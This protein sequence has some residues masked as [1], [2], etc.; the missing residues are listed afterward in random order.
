MI[1]PE[2]VRSIRQG[3]FYGVKSLVSVVLNEGLEVLGT[4]EQS[5][6]QLKFC[7]VFHESGL[8]RVRLPST[9]KVIR[10]EAFMGCKNLKSV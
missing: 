8:K 5:L 3:S 1:F 7:G 6:N 9:L 10:N 2:M 4:E